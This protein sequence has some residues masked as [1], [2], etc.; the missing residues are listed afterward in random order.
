MYY[1]DSNIIIE[2]LRGRLPRGLELLRNTDSRLIGIPD[3]VVAEL[4]V[5]VYKSAHP[6]KNLHAVEQ[7][8][9][10]YETVPFDSRCSSVYAKVRT[11][12]ERAGNKI[13]PNDLIIA[14]TAL[15]HDAILVTNNVDEFKRIPS[16]RIMSLA[17]IEMPA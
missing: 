9:C 13:G 11:D 7:L 6:E 12:L 2:F 1:L 8:L 10:N 5:G 14:A 17:E 16:L 4:Y 15:A 3:I